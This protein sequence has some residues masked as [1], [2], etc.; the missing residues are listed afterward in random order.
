MKDFDEPEIIL[1]VEINH[2]KKLFKC[3]LS[4]LS[5]VFMGE[6]SMILCQVYDI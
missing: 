4:T 2:I 5:L 6:M 3:T 1:K